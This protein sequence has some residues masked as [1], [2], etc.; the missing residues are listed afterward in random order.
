[1]QFVKALPATTPNLADKLNLLARRGATIQ[2]VVATFPGLDED[3][4]LS[5]ILPQQTLVVIY[6]FRGD[7]DMLWHVSVVPG[8]GTC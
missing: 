8:D 5:S 4:P 2:Q 3:V 7:G 1:M 6:E